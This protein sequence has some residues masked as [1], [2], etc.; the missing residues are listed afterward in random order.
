MLRGKKKTR[1]YKTPSTLLFGTWLVI[2]VPRLLIILH[3]WHPNDR[4][5]ITEQQDLS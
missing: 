5:S 4:N 1:I 3:Y 2:H